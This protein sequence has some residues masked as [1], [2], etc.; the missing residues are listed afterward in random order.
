MKKLVSI[1]VGGTGQF[2]L[3][4]SQ[5]LLKKNYK[6]IITTRTTKNK[7]K[8]KKK[9]KKLILYKLNIYDKKEIKSLLY[10]FKPNIVFYYAGQSSPAKSFTNKRETYRS[11]FLGCKNFLEVIHENNYNCK[12]LNAS[13]C[14]I[15]GRINNKIKISSPKKPVNPYGL[16]KLKSFEITKKFRK[17]Y[18]LHTYNAIIFNTESFLRDKSFLIPKYVLLPLMQKSI[19]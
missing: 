16:S 19:I 6:V 3:I 1:I 18:N 5:L 14:E 8:I 11:N 10:K 17:K 13:S 12:F 4:T 2:G 15:F 7:K 9:N